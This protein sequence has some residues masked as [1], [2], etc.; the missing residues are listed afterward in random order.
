[1]GTMKVL[2]ITDGTETIQSIALNIQEALNAINS[3]KKTTAKICPAHEFHGKELLPSEL[4]LIGCETPSPSSFAWLEEMLSHINLASRKCGVFSVNTKTVNYLRSI[5]KDS[6]AE[7][8]EPFIAEKGAVKKA[9]I[10][11]WIKQITKN[12]G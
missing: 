8:A 2:I 9:D 1:M 7:I 12:R 11:K 6:E 5:L 3:E 4:F 10:K